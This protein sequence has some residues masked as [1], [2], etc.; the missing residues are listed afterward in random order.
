MRLAIP[1]TLAAAA[2]LLSLSGLASPAA[3]HLVSVTNFAFTPGDL[4]IASGDSVTWQNN[5]TATPH[6]ATEDLNQWDTGGI[7]AGGGKVTLVFNTPGAYNYYCIH[8][9]LSMR[10]TL[11]VGQ[12]TV[13]VQDDRSSPRTW[14]RIKGLYS[15]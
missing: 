9:P 12:Q 1:G 10:A 6:T 2:A 5:T 7:P 13:G 15:D 3:N 11:T 14:G 8:H 4:T